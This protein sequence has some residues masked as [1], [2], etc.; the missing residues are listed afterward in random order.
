[1]GEWERSQKQPG[2]CLK[3]ETEE[4]S[5]S[6]S[7]PCPKGV[8]SPLRGPGGP[9]GRPRAAPTPGQMAVGTLATDTAAPLPGA[10]LGVCLPLGGGRGWK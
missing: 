2:F 10:I 7:R 1:M 3:G 6:S 8:G 4:S 5:F 9:R